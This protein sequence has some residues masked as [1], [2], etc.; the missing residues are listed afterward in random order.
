MLGLSKTKRKLRWDRLF[1]LALIIAL[2]CF[3][4]Y[5]FYPKKYSVI[6]DVKFGVADASFDYANI[7]LLSKTDQ[8]C[9]IIIDS[10]TKFLSKEALSAGVEKTIQISFNVTSGKSDIKIYSECENS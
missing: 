7:T 6:K 3:A 4:I 5:S 9:N 8:S 1:F 10:G 2:L